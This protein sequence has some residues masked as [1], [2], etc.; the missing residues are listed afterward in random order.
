MYFNCG[1]GGC[2]YECPL[3]S[4]AFQAPVERKDD[5]RSIV[6]DLVVE[7]IANTDWE[8]VSLIL[9]Q[10]G[11]TLP[12]T[13][14]VLCAAATITEESHFIYMIKTWGENSLP[15]SSQVLEAAA[16][17]TNPSDFA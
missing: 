16:A 2:E 11:I 10:A 14:K 6:E 12:V 15:L 4:I 7:R 9:D 17:L 3:Q 13:D 1:E 8:A 5:I